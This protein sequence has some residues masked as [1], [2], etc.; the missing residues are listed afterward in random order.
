MHKPSM[1]SMLIGLIPCTAMC[2]SVPLWDRVYPFVLGLPFN[3]FWI[4]LWI[5]I[6]PLF[7]SVAYRIET[8]RIA[9]DARGKEGGAHHG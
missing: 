7:M 8:Q 2:F 1:K 9:A 6:T 4:I 3:I 5:L